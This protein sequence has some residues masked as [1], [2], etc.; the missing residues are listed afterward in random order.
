MRSSRA[1]ARA[2]SKERSLGIPT[3]GPSR[4]RKSPSGRHGP[5]GSAFGVETDEKGHFYLTGITPGK[6]L[7]LTERDGYLPSSIA[8]HGALRMPAIFSLGAGDHLRDVTIRLRP[9]AV[10]A[11][12]VKYDDGE[13][14]V[15]ILVRVY[16]QIHR[17]GQ[18][19]YSV[20]GQA[21]TDNLGEYRVH[22]LPPGS[23]YIA[24]MYDRGPEKGVIQEPKLDPQ[25]HPLPDI[26]YS[27]TFYPSATRLFETEPI[28]LGYGQEVDGMEIVLNA[29]RRVSIRGR[30]ASAVS[31]AAVRE[32]SITLER[33]DVE[34][35][36]GLPLTVNPIYNNDGSFTIRGVPPGLYI[37]GLTSSD[38]D[39][40][41]QA[42]VPLSTGQGDIDDL[43][44]NLEPPRPPS[45]V[46]RI[47]GEP[48][49]AWRKL[50]L[51][52]EPR[53]ASAV[54]VRADVEGM[55]FSAALA[56]G[57]TYDLFVE[58]L[59]DDAYV[60]SIRIANAD[61]RAGGISA[62]QTGASTP[63]ELVL[64]TPGATISGRA[65]TNTGDMASGANVSIV[66]V[67]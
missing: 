10:V 1:K 34:N 22:G 67:E 58:N 33:V 65:F 11:G 31:G 28:H 52:F 38:G 30:E 12:K 45:G 54:T 16:R 5:G 64:A 15:G 62:N 29:V 23:Y 46:V 53:S 41:V 57:E 50:R 18:R 49:S 24:A 3:A 17:R 32:P 35:T 63:I 27:T 51:S 36:A 55:R 2:V 43:D 21:A 6:Y 7:F 37:L 9:W 8:R 61:A 19:G 48:K 56:A 39:Q 40:L 4:A 44:V 13:P 42:R 60:K 59:P 14:A 20:E 25:G 47:E 26:G 66:P